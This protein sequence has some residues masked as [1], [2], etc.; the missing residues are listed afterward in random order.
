MCYSGV[1]LKMVHVLQ[2]CM[3]HNSAFVPMV[4]VLQVVQSQRALGDAFAE[5]SQKSPEL[6][7]EFAYN[8][9]TQRVI[10]KNGETLIGESDVFTS[11]VS[12][13]FTSGVSDVF[14]SGVSD[15]FMS[16]VSDV[17]TSVTRKSDL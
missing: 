7:E 14:M 2:W 6:Q 16:G 10:S 17:F 12:D 3:Y 1:C 4:H 15:V 11:G 13:V 5:M 9:E 8:C